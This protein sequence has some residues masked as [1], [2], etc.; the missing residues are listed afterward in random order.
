M[1]D[2]LENHAAAH[3]SHLAPSMADWRRKMTDAIGAYSVPLSQ[4]DRF[5][6][7]EA[8]RIPKSIYESLDLQALHTALSERHDRLHKNSI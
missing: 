1:T 3:C 7:Y 6:I 8:S 5:T 4:L 2:E